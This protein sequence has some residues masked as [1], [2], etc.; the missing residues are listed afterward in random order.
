M[1]LYELEEN[2]IYMLN[3]I[4]YKIE[5]G[6]LFNLNVSN[7]EWLE[8]K[9]TFSYEEL[10]KNDYTEF[11]LINDYTPKVGQ[12]YWYP[13]PSAVEGVSESDWA[14]HPIDDRRKLRVG[15]FKT[16]EEAEFKSKLLGW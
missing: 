11:V 14:G 13:N 1:K 2:K 8:S 6:K 15:V 5:R 9:Q 4:K 16:K 12:I 10:L 7:N 3:D